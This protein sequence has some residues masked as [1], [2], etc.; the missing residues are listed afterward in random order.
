MNRRSF[1]A[2]T[3]AVA[4]SAAATPDVVKAAAPVLK[5]P[6]KPKPETVTVKVNDLLFEGAEVAHRMAHLLRGAHPLR[7]RFFSME[8]NGDILFEFD[9]LESCTYTPP[10]GLCIDMPIRAARMGDILSI[11][12][13]AEVSVP[14]GAEAA[15]VM[16]QMNEVSSKIYKLAPK[17]VSITPLNL[18]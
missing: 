11:R 4:A 13:R 7:L 2:K 3:F 8:D 5:S 6:P 9:V 1:L 16:R 18:P 12:V 14:M 15:R 17:T 10:D